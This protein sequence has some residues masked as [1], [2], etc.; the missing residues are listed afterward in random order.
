MEGLS[1]KVIRGIY[2]RINLQVYS[3]DLA[4]IIKSMLQVNPELRPSCQQILDSPEVKQY[5]DE[6]CPED[7]ESSVEQ[8]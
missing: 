8:Q 3:E 4:V 6:L 5:S 2:P 7:D 1:K